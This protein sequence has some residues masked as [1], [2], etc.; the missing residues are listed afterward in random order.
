MS[1]RISY[2]LGYFLSVWAFGR[3]DIDEALRYL[4]N[5]PV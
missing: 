2:K 5:P 4:F 3:A 1:S